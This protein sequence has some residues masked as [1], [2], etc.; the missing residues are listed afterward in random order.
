MPNS[1]PPLAAPGLSGSSSI[2]SQPLTRPSGHRSHRTRAYRAILVEAEV[3]PH[4]PATE[5]ETWRHE[6][7]EWLG[8]RKLRSSGELLRSVAG[9]LHAMASIGLKW[10]DHWEVTPGGW[11]PLPRSSRG[12]QVSS[13]DLL[14]AFEGDQ[15]ESLRRARALKLRLSGPTGFRVDAEIHRARLRSGTFIRLGF[16]GHIPSDQLSHILDALRS[17]LPVS[18]TTVR[19][20]VPA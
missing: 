1:P 3:S 19:H 17:R 10:V 12:P 13:R 20:K 7:E 2:L 15:E 8:A 16:A 14:D 5:Q 11:L 4:A 6:I 18:R 9:T